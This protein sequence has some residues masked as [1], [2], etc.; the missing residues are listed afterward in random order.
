MIQIYVLQYNLYK[1]GKKIN[2]V[3]TDKY[4]ARKFN[5]SSGILEVNVFQWKLNANLKNS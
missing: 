1:L 3:F 5:I 4:T 2:I